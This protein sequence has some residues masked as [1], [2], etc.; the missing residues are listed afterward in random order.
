MNKPES[1]AQSR[2]SVFTLPPLEEEGLHAKH[3]YVL[4]KPKLLKSLLTNK[5]TNDSED[6]DSDLFEHQGPNREPSVTSKSQ[7]GSMSSK[8]LVDPQNKSLSP[9]PFKRPN[10]RGAQGKKPEKV[11]LNFLMLSNSMAEGEACSDDSEEETGGQLTRN[12]NR[13]AQS[14]FDPNK[15]RGFMDLLEYRMMQQKKEASDSQDR[16]PE[17]EV[18]LD[19]IKI[20]REKKRKEFGRAPWRPKSLMR[21]TLIRG[22]LHPPLKSKLKPRGKT[23]SFGTN[24]VL[25][26]IKD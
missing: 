16:L 26:Y 19:E 24:M 20:A 11:N 18:D 8:K 17:M 2:I 10:S 13:E 3:I 25:T 12:Q 21:R 5:S 9:E 1:G 15:V 14:G 4:K 23:I 22:R 7:F 6:N